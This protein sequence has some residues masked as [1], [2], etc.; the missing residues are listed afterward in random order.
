MLRTLAVA[1]A[2]L[3]M[4][5][6]QT[7]A[8][9]G[10]PAAATA[11]SAAP[12]PAASGAASAWTPFSADH[13]DVGFRMG[14]VVVPTAKTEDKTFEMAFFHND[15]VQPVDF[16]AGFSPDG[17][18]ANAVYFNVHVD[19]GSVN[20][21]FLNFSRACG[22]DQTI[23]FQNLF[24]QKAYLTAQQ[25]PQTSAVYVSCTLTAHSITVDNGASVQLPLGNANVGTFAV[26]ERS[27]QLLAYDPVSKTF[28]DANAT[29]GKDDVAWFYA[30]VYQYHL[31]PKT[32]AFYRVGSY[33]EQSNLV[34]PP[35]YTISDREDGQ[36]QK[37]SAP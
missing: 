11:P 20:V 28:S 6:A 1:V 2:A 16:Q 3:L 4:F 31:N 5:T 23:F 32:L 29:F 10:T 17:T 14:C 35:D 8:P 36:C 24:A 12:S 27:Q 30:T 7:P 18:P 25:T 13:P 15:G 33:K 37:T 22:A 19:A 34:T 21:S 26:D 9:S